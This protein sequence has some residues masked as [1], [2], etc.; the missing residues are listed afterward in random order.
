MIAI[1]IWV[2]AVYGITMRLQTDITLYVDTI[3][4]DYD[5]VLAVW[6]GSPG[7]FTL[8]ACND[9]NDRATTGL[10]SK[11]GFFAQA[12]TTYYVEVIQY[13]APAGTVVEYDPL[14]EPY[15][16]YMEGGILSFMW[17]RDFSVLWMYPLEA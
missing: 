3:G 6:K 17:R 16:I 12:G 1:L 11:I 4:T 8:V 5:T 10:A 9:D 2:I 14:T 13:S 15:P 7:S